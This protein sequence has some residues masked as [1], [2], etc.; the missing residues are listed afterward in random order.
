MAVILSNFICNFFVDSL[1]D[2]K[3]TSCRKQKVTSKKRMREAKCKKNQKKWQEW[4]ERAGN[5][6]KSGPSEEAEK[7]LFYNTSVHTAKTQ[8]IPLN[9]D[10]KLDRYEYVEK[11]V[12]DCANTRRFL[13]DT[14]NSCNFVSTSS[15][16]AT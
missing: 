4:M 14:L 11:T 10:T 13:A 1:L 9:L 5:L 2:L 8:N 3:M 6:K 15:G 7:C 16:T 12:G